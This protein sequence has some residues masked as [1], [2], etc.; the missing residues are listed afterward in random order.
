[1]SSSSRKASFLLC[2]LLGCPGLF[3]PG[4]VPLALS[5]ENVRCNGFTPRPLFSYQVIDA[6]P[7]DR[8]AFTQGLVFKDGVLIEGTG[9]HGRSSVRKVEL[10]TGNVLKMRRL[11]RRYFGEGLTVFGDTVIQLTWKSGVGFVYNKEDLRP[12]GKFYYKGQ[13]WGLTHDG[14]R[15]IMSDGTSSLRF[16]DPFTF[17]ELG[18]VEVRYAGAPLINLNELEYVR[19]RVYANVWGTECIVIIDPG[20]G[21]VEGWVSLQGLLGPE[22]TGPEVDVLNGIAYDATDDRLFVTGKFWPKLFEIKVRD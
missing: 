16:L 15:L 22:D 18:K 4:E 14:L 6:Y 7:H 19:G 2:I 21:L 10:A 9:R 8:G 17:E 5:Q 20:T 1:M 13:G 11:P 3:S 12:L